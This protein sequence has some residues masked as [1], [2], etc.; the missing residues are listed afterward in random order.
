MVFP[1][2]GIWLNDTLD[3][4]T[5]TF[6]PLSNPAT[7]SN[8][9]FYILTAFRPHSRLAVSKDLK[10]RLFAIDLFDSSV[11]R[12][13]IAW[14]YDFTI[15]NLK[16][17]YLE[18]SETFC[19]EQTVKNTPIG[20]HSLAQVAISDNFV[21]IL[22][23]YRE[24][25]VFVDPNQYNH[26][27][28]LI[29]EDQGKLFTVRFSGDT[30]NAFQALA[31]STNTSY[32]TAFYY[33]RTKQSILQQHEFPR[34]EMTGEINISK[35]LNVGDQQVNITSDITFLQMD[36][37]S[38]LCSVCLLTMWGLNYWLSMFSVRNY[39]GVLI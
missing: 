27:R 15:A 30:E 28:M 34:G 14:Y 3:S 39:C 22:F 18:T 24:P 1:H 32:W 25:K 19:T 10:L 11:F 29:V 20:R 2:A 38:L 23:R 12:I 8:N 4:E 35:L 37:S 13:S 31:F 17:P 9:R 36:S 5:G 33:I 16:L 26:S 21:T 6:I 7:H